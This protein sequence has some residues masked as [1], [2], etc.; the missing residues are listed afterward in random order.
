M[1]KIKIRKI[2][3]L[4]YTYRYDLFAMSLIFI[5]VMIFFETLFQPG[6]IVFSDIDFPFNSKTY[7]KE[8]VG[9]WNGKWNTTSMLNIPR[10][11]IV[12]PSYLVA[13]IFKNNGSI[14]LKTFLLQQSLMSAFSIYLL[15]K[16]LVSVYYGKAFDI[17]KI[18]ALIFGSLLY[19]LNPYFV[20]RIQH[21][22]LLVGYSFFP[23]IIL[24]F[25]KVF[26]HKFQSAV[27]PSY[28]AVSSKLYYENYRDIFILSL[29]ITLGSA[30]IHYFFYSV[31]AL[32]TIFLLLIMKYM[33]FK[34][35]QVYLYKKNVM[36]AIIKKLL[37]FIVLFALLSFYW[38]SIY[39]GSILVDAE[40]SQHNINEIDTYTMFSRNSDIVNVVF[41]DS[42]WWKMMTHSKGISFYL[43]GGIIL[44]VILTGAITHFKRHHAIT[45][46]T[47]LGGI[48][49]LLATGVN[50]PIIKDVFLILCRIP[51]FGNVF[52][53]PNKLIGLLAVSYSVL[54]IF[55]V[56][57]LVQLFKHKS[58]LKII[59]FATIS[60]A[61]VMYLL[62]MKLYFVDEYYRPIEI[63][64]AYADLNQE[65]NESERYAVYLPTAEQMIRPIYN[66]ATPK[67]NT[68]TS[69]ETKATGDVHIYNAPLDTLF[70]HEG[71]NPGI[72]YYLNYLQYLLDTGRTKHLM[73][74]LS[75][76][77]ADT[78]IYHDEY[79]DQSERQDFNKTIIEVQDNSNKIYENDIFS[80]YDVPSTR[81]NAD[82]KIWTPYGLSHLET[83]NDLKEYDI[84]RNP[85]V[86]MSQR[87]EAFYDES[88][89][90]DYLE[91]YSFD[92]VFLETLDDDYKQ[93]PF[94][95]VNELNPFMKWSKTYLS[96][97]DWA[98]FMKQIDN[99]SRYF[100]Y[101]QEN[102][103]A[104]TFATGKLDIQP[105]ERKYASG[106][107]VID[108]D[109]MIRTDTFF[110]ADTPALYEV[111]ANPLVDLNSVGV[112]RGVI[113]KGDP[114]DIWQVAKSKLIPATENTP[115]V[116]DI[117]LSG[118]HVNKLHV[119]VRYFDANRKEVGVQYVVAPDEVVDFEAV[120]FSGETI[121]PK[122][123]KYMRMD[124]LSFQK[125]EVKSYWWIH[126]VNIYDYSEYK[127]KNTITGTYTSEISDDYEL[128]VKVFQSPS[129]GQV[130]V[131]I[132]NQTFEVNTSD[133]LFGFTW[134]YLGDVY[135][136]EGDHLVDIENI[137][138]FNSIN[139]IVYLPKSK[140]REL[141][142]PAEKQIKQLTQILTFEGENNFYYEGNIQS[143]RFNPAYSYGKGLT[144]KNGLAERSFEIINAGNYMISSNMSFY[145]LNDTA[146]ITIVDDNQEI[147]YQETVKPQSKVNNQ[148]TI[149]FSPLSAGYIYKVVNREN[150]RYE[151]E[152]LSIELPFVKGRY[153]MSIEFDSHVT[154]HSPVEWL[155]K[156][157]SNSLL[158]SFS[159][160]APYAED[161][162]Q[163]ESISYDM[164]RSHLEND[165][166]TIEYEPTCSCDWYI[167]SSKKIP[168]VA[169]EE[170]RVEFDAVSEDIKSRHSKLVY[171]DQFDHVV[172]TQF[173]F[174]IEEEK[175]SKWHRYEQL[176][177]VPEGAAYVL[178]QFWARG[179]QEKEG[180]LKLQNLTLERYDEYVVLDNILIQQVTQKSHQN[181]E[182]IEMTI[183]TDMKK[184]VV[185]E[186]YESP[187]LWNSYLSPSN[188]WRIDG[189]KYDYILNGVTMGYQ[190]KNKQSDVDVVLK[191]VYQ[192]GIILHVMTIIL[193]IY[194]LIRFKRRQ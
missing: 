148:T 176:D 138:G 81:P 83:F 156:F 85:T 19:A 135:L 193:S 131:T 160:E 87:N 66:I 145:D 54:F 33:L 8:I 129:S 65:F 108:F 128:Y 112:V 133:E 72:S 120:K 70:H 14:F 149:N 84:L 38:L 29:L 3:S 110:E 163:C 192:L 61:S 146:T 127:T 46:L 170:L 5:A 121:S 53:D 190:L 69:L 115:Y 36:T 52:R 123:T 20:Y 27:I 116:Y 26:D 24:Y 13:M 41:L 12:L 101:D 92:D 109:T 191:R 1:L 56:E 165:I 82:Y 187:L 159:P 94:N 99:K 130:N 2:E 32:G 15:S 182:I 89:Y 88:N 30:A 21:I 40:A 106:Q 141:E 91:T 51:F 34:R 158:V 31:L 57:S 175:K 10:L 143:E 68:T 35:Q 113:S 78:F 118:R 39:A 45:L 96:N 178:L 181:D 86:F 164:F 100:E 63:P 17:Y 162:S 183:D 16:R 59:L 90:G 189:N 22:Y 114:K 79:L 150:I 71:N 139:Q 95:W 154:N 103:V 60:L 73:A 80:V 188:L 142:I 9:L 172:E 47:I 48:M 144:L 117:L 137:K 153:T 179:D 111:Q 152:N 136:E 62:P 4:F 122:D 140:K 37:I 173:I 161:C 169:Q 18:I 184:R 126:D 44:I 171:V 155:E 166:L 23:L 180:Y 74:Y 58:S 194:F 75:T 107:L 119:K 132:E 105:H 55:G 7:L 174:E 67:W 49:M 147:Y 134:Q 6:Q 125:P 97:P 98:W 93:Y 28:S 102:G 151:N 186:N 167:Y 11:L 76:F 104:V 50:Y 77:G 64:E 177:V 168:V 124:L 25:F 185:A 42:Y 157:D 43:G